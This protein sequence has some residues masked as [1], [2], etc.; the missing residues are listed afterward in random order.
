MSIHLITDSCCELPDELKQRIRPDVAPL[1]VT[2]IGGGEYLDDGT[3]SIP[4]LLADMA[5]SRKGAVSAC[6]SVDDFAVHMERHDQCFVVTLSSKLS[7]SYNAARVAAELVLESHPHK[8]I[9]VFDSESAS[10]GEALL[11][12]F[13]HEKIEQGLTFEQIIPLAN[14][15]I[16]TMKTMFVL[17]DLGNLLKSGR[18]KKL[19]GMIASALSL[20]P[21]MSDNGHGEIKLL[22]KARGIQNALRRLIDIIREHTAKE[23]KQS[24]TMM[25][26]FCNCLE[27]AEAFRAQILAVCPAIK[28]ILMV[29]TGALSA[30]YANDGGIIV[31][32]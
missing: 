21:I 24:I 12:H 15:K 7:G 13:L 32:F 19:P 29:P 17:E 10:A 20:C 27:R 1:K 28:N 9:H 25:M 8:K 4:E 18:L 5:A 31:A 14:Q 16:A 30:M 23:N 26:T 11:V 6:P 3:V 22:D 2:V